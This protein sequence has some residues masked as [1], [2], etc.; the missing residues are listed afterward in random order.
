MPARRSL[1]R[2]S[3]AAAILSLGGCG[4]SSPTQPPAPA[5]P[6]PIAFASHESAHFVFRHMPLDA[7]TIA[8]TAAAVEA[9]HARIADDLGVPGIP[10]VRVT[11]YPD[12]DALRAG[13]API[14]GTIPGFASGLVTGPAD[15][16]VLSPN[17]GAQWSYPVGVTAIVHEFAHC[18]SMRLN[19]SIANNPRW[20]WESVALYEAGQ[21]VD[22]RT[23]AFMTAGQPPTLAELNRI[24]DARVYQVGGLIGAFVVD[25]WGRE[26]LR[27]LVR[28]NGRVQA[29][30][31]DEAGFT[32]RWFAYAR[33]RYGF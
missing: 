23:L 11:L 15:I 9:Q 4:G 13:V 17:L 29:L 1:S 22:P 33:A 16:H 31:V 27:D 19:P 28:T 2:A 24:E 6:S 30:G 26:A 7:A 14:V 5:A 32:S 20:L 25:T 10:A 18:A 8:A 12:A 3:L 21:V